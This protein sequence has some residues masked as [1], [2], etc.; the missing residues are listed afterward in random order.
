MV[1]DSEDERSGWVVAKLC[2]KQKEI[3]QRHAAG[4][5]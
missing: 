1:G 4:T 3:H 2:Q 5:R